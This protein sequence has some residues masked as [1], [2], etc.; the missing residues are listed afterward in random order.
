MALFAGSR[1]IGA[2]ERSSNRSAERERENKIKRKPLVIIKGRRPRLGWWD[3]SIDVVDGDG[4]IEALLQAT[5]PIEEKK[6]R[7][8]YRRDRGFIPVI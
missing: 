6:V 7:H 4:E 1:L 5:S 2:P 3:S 8:R